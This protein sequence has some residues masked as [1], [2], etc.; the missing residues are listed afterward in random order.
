MKS[1][2]M[3]YATPSIVGLFL[4][5]LISGIA[6]FF[7]IGPAA[8]HGIHEW[9]SMILIVAFA[10]HVWRNW[11]PMLAYMKGK[12]LALAMAVSIAASAIFF[13]PFGSG[14]GGRPPVFALAQTVI[15]HTPAEVAPALG[16]TADEL[17]ARLSAAGYQVDTGQS[18]AAIA[19][20]SGKSTMDLAGLLTR[21]AD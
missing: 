18:L 10:L 2:L 8:F 21:P 20:A 17:T 12:P 9:L 4:V 19:A 3:R 14:G 11:R 15:R 1:V 7:H 6:L 13:L 16:L 5:S